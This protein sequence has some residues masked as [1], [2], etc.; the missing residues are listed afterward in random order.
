[1][2]LAVNDGGGGK[3]M[4]EM[5]AYI[6]RKGSYS[7][8]ILRTPKGDFGLVG[9]VPAALCDRYWKTE[10]EV[11]DA[12]LGIGIKRFQLANCEWYEV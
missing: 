2:D 11:I 10:Q 7:T 9:S 5:S 1:M 6:N 8:A 3:K 4:N 12:L